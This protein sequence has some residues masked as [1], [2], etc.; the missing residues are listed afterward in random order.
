LAL[1]APLVIDQNVLIRYAIGP[2]EAYC[3]N[4][5]FN[6]FMSFSKSLYFQVNTLRIFRGLKDIRELLGDRGL[7]ADVDRDK[8]V[9][10]N[11][12]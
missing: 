10:I 4:L 5:P 6:G 12:I 9:D 7:H 3:N 8:Y 11:K 2:E 1:T